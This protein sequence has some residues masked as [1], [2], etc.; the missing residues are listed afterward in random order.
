[1]RKVKSILPPDSPVTVPEVYLYDEKASALSTLIDD[2]S[3]R[4]EEALAQSGETV[5]G[6]IGRMADE[7]TQR[8]E[9]AGTALTDT[10]GRQADDIRQRSDE[11]VSR[12]SAIGEE[13]DRRIREANESVIERLASRAEALGRRGR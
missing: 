12:V 13:A 6:R 2:R 9:E 1:M 7:T 11:I 10:L 4:V 8:L 5:V 3:R